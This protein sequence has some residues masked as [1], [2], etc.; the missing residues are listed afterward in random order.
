[1]HQVMWHLYVCVGGGVL[2]DVVFVRAYHM[3][4]Y[5]H[6]HTNTHTHTHMHTYVYIR[7]YIHTFYMYIYI[8]I[9]ISAPTRFLLLGGAWTGSYKHKALSRPRHPRIQQQA[10]MVQQLAVLAPRWH[11]LPTAR[12]MA[13]VNKT[14]HASVTRAGEVEG[15]RRGC[16]SP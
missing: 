8:Y 10:V 9:Y 13:C 14:A 3:Y 6:T 1:M 15:V 2:C 5:T 16:M 12:N 4:L 7:T 11:A